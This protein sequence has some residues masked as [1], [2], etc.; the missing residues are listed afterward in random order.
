LNQFLKIIYE[1]KI[2]PTK[3]VDLKENESLDFLLDEES[4][5][6]RGWSSL[7]ERGTTPEHT[8]VLKSLER[9]PTPH[10]SGET[11]VSI[12]GGWNLMI[13]KYSSNVSE[14]VKFINFITSEESQKLMYKEGGYLPVLNF[15]Y[16]DE[17]FI[18]QNPDLNFY[19][20]LMKQ[21]AHRPFFKKYTIFSDILAKTIHSALKHE[22]SVDSAVNMA[23]EKIH[24]AGIV[25]QKAD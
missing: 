7:K 19:K 12:F 21:G 24:K 17:Q 22:I 14:S 11:P 15:I 18:K 4:F 25:V 23:Y 2:S 10:F 9:A 1:D 8:G 16:E 3:V 6:V 20:N 13:S 5:S